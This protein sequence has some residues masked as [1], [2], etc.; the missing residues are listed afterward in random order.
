MK[1]QKDGKKNFPLK[2][3]LEET[4]NSTKKFIKGEKKILGAENKKHKT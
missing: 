4:E 2:Y 1:K 3:K